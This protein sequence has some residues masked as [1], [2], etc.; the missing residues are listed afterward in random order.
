MPFKKKIHGT[1]NDDYDQTTRVRQ[2]NKKLEYGVAK[3]PSKYSMSKHPFLSIQKAR[4]LRKAERA[5]DVKEVTWILLSGTLG[6]IARGV[7]PTL[8]KQFV[9][10]ATQQLIRLQD[11]EEAYEK[12][13]ARAIEDAG[14]QPEDDDE[15]DSWL[16]DGEEA[17]SDFDEE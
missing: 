11:I 4:D 3:D 12:K 1:K 2:P 14:R 16:E 6:E 8:G 7:E 15:L 17:A 5:Q 9:K 13:L 10:T